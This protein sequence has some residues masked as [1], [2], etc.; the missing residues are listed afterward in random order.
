[1]VMES[2]GKGVPRE[3]GPVIYMSTFPHSQLVTWGPGEVPKTFKTMHPVAIVHGCSPE[4]DGET[5]LL[6]TPQ[7]LDT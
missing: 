6:K 7:N 1:M 5:L 2:E 3:R 4:L